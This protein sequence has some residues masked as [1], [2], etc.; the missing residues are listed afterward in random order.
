MATRP[1]TSQKS[2]RADSARVHEKMLAVARELVAGGDLEPPMNALA[3]A[4]GVGVGTVYRHFPSHQA[5]LESLAARSLLTL[6]DDAEAAAADPDVAAGLT[7]LLGAALRLQLADPSLAA[8]LAT[9]EAI[10]IATV[11][12]HRQLGSAVTRLLDRARQSGVIRADITADD[13]RRLTCGVQHAV[14]LGPADDADRYLH[15]LVQGLRP[16]SEL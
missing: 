6:V 12:M 4:A 14:R 16:V 11:E 10:C 5:L 3:R 9:P 7:R 15:I 1:A 13:I 8:V 2:F